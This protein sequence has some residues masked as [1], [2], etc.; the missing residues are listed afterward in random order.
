MK[1]RKGCRG[2]LRPTG[3]GSGGPPPTY[4]CS[5]AKGGPAAPWQGDCQDQSPKEGPRE[6]HPS[7]WLCPHEASSLVT[8]GPCRGL[9]SHSHPW[10]GQGPGAPSTEHHSQ[11][12]KRPRCLWVQLETGGHYVL[13]ITSCVSTEAMTTEPGFTSTPQAPEA[14]PLI[15]A[16]APASPLRRSTPLLSVRSHD[17][18][19]K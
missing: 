1:T 8:S 5:F 3:P 11:V 13:P 4:H 18:V 17:A 19:R 7:G 14:P 9:G 12:G 6:D 15:P 16:V 2:R 10:N